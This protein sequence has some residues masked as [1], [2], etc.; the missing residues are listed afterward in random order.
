MTLPL[1]PTRFPAPAPRFRAAGPAAARPR[2]GVPRVTLRTERAMPGDLAARRREQPTAAFLD[3]GT[4]SVEGR[5]GRALLDPLWAVAQAAGEPYLVR[6]P[7]GA[8]GRGVA[9]S[10]NAELWPGELGPAVA[11]PGPVAVL[12]SLPT[13]VRERVLRLAV[14]RRS[15]PDL[16]DE[17]ARR[18]LAAVAADGAAGEARARAA[19]ADPARAD[20][21]DRHR[22]A[23][24]R[25]RAHLAAGYR[26]A[27]PIAD[28]ARSAYLSPFHLA[29]VFRAVTGVTVHQYLTRLRLRAA[30]HGFAEPGR[31]FDDLAAS[32]GYSSQGHFTQV[33]RRELGMT[34]RDLRHLVLHGAS[35]DPALPEL[36]R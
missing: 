1:S 8:C 34:P 10:V 7:F 26:Q 35:R 4:W 31:L 23:V 36:G 11:A 12:C 3:E 24:R 16:V 9:V 6:H 19:E 17:A 13:L 25:A 33:V 30:L 21:L 32:V 15:P 22:A 14:A 5:A 2:P 28:V 27:L 20:T 18:L 29:R